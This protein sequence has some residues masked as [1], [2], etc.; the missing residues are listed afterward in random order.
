MSLPA[1]YIPPEAWSGPLF[2]EGQEAAHA[3]V[4]RL[5]PGDRLLA[6]NGEGKVATCVITAM[7]RKKVELNIISESFMSPPKAR[8]ILALALS[9]AVR[10]EFFMEKAAELG[11]FEVWLWHAEFSQGKI[12][13]SLER[14]VKARLVS[15]LK[16]CRGAWLPRL[17]LMPRLAEV[18]RASGQASWRVLPFEGR[19]GVPMLLP[20][21]LG[22]EGDTVYVIGPE[23]GFSAGEI[24]ALFAEGFSPAS[25]GNRVLRCETAATLCLGLHFWASQLPGHPDW[26][27]EEGG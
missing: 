14:S 4:K 21:E 20:S 16:Q 9:K 19:E 11:A 27:G 7:D 24:E 18:I 3:R 2:L 23:G 15:G 25:F 12:E 1:Y 26:Q 5:K 10:R 22:R 8:A 6:L 17:R 13:N